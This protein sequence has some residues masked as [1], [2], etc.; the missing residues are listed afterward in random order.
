M[1]IST[2]SELET[3]LAGIRAARDRLTL[4]AGKNWSN[5]VLPEPTTAAVT[6]ATG[7]MAVEVFP[8][9]KQLNQLVAQLT[10]EVAT[11][12]DATAARVRA[13]QQAVLNPVLDANTCAD[14]IDVEA[15]VTSGDHSP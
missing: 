10:S 2:T 8:P 11:Q 15:K 4:I 9:V 14:V 7:G 3:S 12:I 6:T 13:M 5:A 1:T